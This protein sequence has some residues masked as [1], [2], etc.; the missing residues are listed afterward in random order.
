MKKPDGAASSAL[1]IATSHAHLHFTGRWF[2]KCNLLG[3]G[4]YY[5]FEDDVINLLLESERI[6]IFS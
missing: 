4:F 1:Q 6:A 2:S 5:F 3:L